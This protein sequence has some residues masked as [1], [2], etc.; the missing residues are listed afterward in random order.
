MTAVLDRF[1]EKTS[2]GPIPDH[3]PDLGPCLLWT[4]SLDRDGYGK[5]WDGT[6]VVAAHR[7]AYEEVHGP[8]PPG[9]TVD[10]LCRV[11]ACVRGHHLEAVTNRVNILRGVSPSAIHAQKTACPKGH[12]YDEANTWVDGQGRRHCRSCWRPE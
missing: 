9:L 10:H 8:I 12:R 1:T 11:H 6:K 3:R 7:Q 2:E 4:A 5:F